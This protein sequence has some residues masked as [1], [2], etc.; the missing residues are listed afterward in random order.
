V[1]F[2]SHVLIGVVARTA[3]VLAY[4]CIPIFALLIVMETGND[5]G[6]G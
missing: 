1:G 3:S 2:G 6:N 4:C 5:R